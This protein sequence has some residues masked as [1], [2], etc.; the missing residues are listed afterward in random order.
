MGKVIDLIDEA[1]KEVGGTFDIVPL[2]KIVGE[3][4]ASYAPQEL[5]KEDYLFISTSQGQVKFMLPTEDAGPALINAHI[6]V[7]SPQG[8]V[9]GNGPVSL[10]I[11]AK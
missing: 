7:V 4:R 3:E 9:L 10:W 1:V 8:G 5:Q 11:P 6:V 2:Q